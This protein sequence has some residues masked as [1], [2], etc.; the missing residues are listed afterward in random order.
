MRRTTLVRLKL[1]A[2]LFALGGAALS[3]PAVPGTASAQPA[4][5]ERY[6][7]LV[8]L[9]PDDDNLPTN[10]RT[11]LRNS[12]LRWSHDD[13][14]PDHEI[15]A[16]GSVR[17]RRLGDGRYRHQLASGPLSGCDHEGASFTSADRTRPRDGEAGDE[18]FFLDLDNDARGGLG[19]RARVYYDYQPGSHV[20]YWLFYAFNDAPTGITGA[21]DHEGDWE[22]IS[23]R[24]DS[25]N[26]A[27]DMA[28][29]AHNGHC[30]LP[31]DQVRT[32]RGHPVVYS[33]NGTHASYPTAGEHGFDETAQGPRWRTWRRLLNVRTRPWYGFG[34]AWGEVGAIVDT[35]GPLGPSR[36]KPAAPSDW[37]ERC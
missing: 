24:L 33:A 31:W 37:T 22:R 26:R 34:G 1:L 15:A 25:Q 17:G 30:T 21:F 13:A 28:F 16:Q 35:T 11:F 4:P 23:V 19:T 9:H 7:P 10:A 8:F 29:F 12:S 20:T 32:V 6:A 18:G 27:T 36:Y 2:G 14:C 3:I 5:V